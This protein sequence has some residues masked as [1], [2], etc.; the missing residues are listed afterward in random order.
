MDRLDREDLS[1]QQDAL[2][3]ARDGLVD[4]L[5][6]LIDD[7]RAARRAASGTKVNLPRITA[8]LAPVYGASRA[9]ERAEQLLDMA[10]TDLASA[11]GEDV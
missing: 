6:R 7:A 9:V 10:A 2:A 8:E 11:S 3:R 5:D 1:A 4:A